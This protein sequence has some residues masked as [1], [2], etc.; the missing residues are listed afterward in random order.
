MFIYVSVVQKN[1]EI[2]SAPVVEKHVEVV[3]QAKPQ[4]TYVQRTVIP[5]YV[6]KTIHVPSYV[7]KTVRVP[8]LVEKTVRVPA[9]PTIIEKTVASPPADVDFEKR[10]V[11]PFNLIYS[12]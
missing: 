3:E 9:P 12:T 2:S 4:T 11:E 10:Y 7:E 1:V 8:T 6:E 5:N